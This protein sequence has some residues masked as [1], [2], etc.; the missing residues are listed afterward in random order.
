MPISALADCI[1]ETEADVAASS[2][3]APL[4]GHVGDGNF[5]LGIIVDPADAAERAR[6]EALARRTGERAIRFGGTCSGEHG[7][8]L[9]KRGLAAIEHGAAAEI[10]W[11]VKRALDPAGIMNPG[12]LLPDAA[13]HEGSPL[14]H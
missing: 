6:A 5:H 2:L 8:G 12:K 11:A 7:V 4:V 10:M 14:R 9:H 3:L 1:T 13:A